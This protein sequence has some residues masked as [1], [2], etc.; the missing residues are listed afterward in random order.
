MK[1]ESIDF[2][3]GNTVSVF[4]MH[5]S[6]QVISWVEDEPL[7][8]MTREENQKVIVD[9]GFCRGTDV[10]K[11][12]ALGADAV[13]IGKM[14]GLSASAGGKDGVYKMLEI[15]EEEIRLTMALLGVTKIGDIGP[16]FLCSA[17]PV[18]MPSVSSAFPHFNFEKFGY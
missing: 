5:P 15:L 17:E 3:Q 1:T 6:F 12:L 14:Y 13:G 18:R 16:E 10:I 9:G 11:A 8:L 4:P 2:Y 7:L